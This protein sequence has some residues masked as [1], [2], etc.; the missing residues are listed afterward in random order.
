MHLTCQ[1]QKIWSRA[2]EKKMRRDFQVGHGSCTL[3]QERACADLLVSDTASYSVSRE[4]VFSHAIREGTGSPRAQQLKFR[5]RHSF[6]Q[7]TVPMPSA[8][9]HGSP[10]RVTHR[11]DEADAHFRRQAQPQGVCLWW[12]ACALVATTLCISGAVSLGALRPVTDPSVNMAASHIASVRQA[13]NGRPVL[14]HDPIRHGEVQPPT[15]PLPR[16]ACTP[17]SDSA[18]QRRAET[19]RV[20]TSG[21]PQSVL[22]RSN[23]VPPAE[24]GP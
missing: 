5:N 18:G 13:G 23:A 11:P 1:S 21:V 20:L 24:Q 6:L 19:P 10:A 8:C 22:R 16:G 15:P 4:G 9:L 2:T 7:I 14:G 12:P 17:T 3:P